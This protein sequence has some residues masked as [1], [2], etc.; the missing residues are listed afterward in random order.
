MPHEQRRT[1]FHSRDEILVIPSDA[2]PKRERRD[3]RPQT[4]CQ[5]RSGARLIDINYSSVDILIFKSPSQ[6]LMHF[7]GTESARYGV[8]STSHSRRREIVFVT[9]FSCLHT[10]VL[11]EEEL[12][13]FLCLHHSRDETIATG[14]SKPI[15][16]HRLPR[17][18]PCSPRRWRPEDY[19][20]SAVI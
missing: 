20:R 7:L 6:A 16:C 10:C 4:C 17:R 2:Q 1:G 5:G 13:M 11:E 8:R 15:I 9:H 14:I 12:Q 18:R 19:S 3:G